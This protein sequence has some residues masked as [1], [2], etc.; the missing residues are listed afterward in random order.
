MT[1]Q[2]TE[3]IDYSIY[4]GREVL[5]NDYIPPKII[6]ITGCD[7]DIGISAQFKD[8]IEQYCFCL[9]GPAT[10]IY[11]EDK[12]LSKPFFKNDKAY[13]DFFKFIIS[14]IDRGHFDSIDLRSM[15]A[16]AGHSPSTK[17]CAFS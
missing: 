6:I 7:K 5:N 14:L 15:I 11:K 1:D 12:T 16:T 9:N 10:K 8:N 4:E 3:E 2:I 17:N 13:Y